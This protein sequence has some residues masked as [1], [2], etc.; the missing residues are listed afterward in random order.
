[1]SKYSMIIVGKAYSTA[2]SF[3]MIN[4]SNEIF[5]MI[6]Q[7]KSHLLPLLMTLFLIDS[8]FALDV[9]LQ[10]VATGL[11]TPVDLVAAPD[12][13]GRLYIVEQTGTIRI[14]M[15]DGTIQSEPFIDVTSKMVKMHAIYDER[16]LLGLAFHPNYSTNGKF[17]IYYSAPIRKDASFPFHLFGNHTSNV[18]EFTVSKGNANQADLGSEKIII[19]VDQPQ[20]NHNGGALRFGPDGYLYIGTGDGGF[21]D[22]WGFGHNKADGNGQD[23]NTLLAKILRIDVNKGNPYDIPAGNPFM[24]QDGARPEIFA[25]GFRNPWKMNFDMGGNNELFVAD[26]GQNSFEAV[27]IVKKGG[28]YGWRVREGAHC[29]DL[30]NPNVQ[31]PNCPSDQMIDPILEYKH[32]TTHPG[33]C[34]GISISGGV[35][36]RGQNSAWTGKYFFADYSMAMGTING[37]LYVASENGGNWSMEDINITNMSDQMSFLAV[38]QDAKGEVY[39]LTTKAFSPGGGKDIIYKLI[40]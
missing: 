31:K 10:A 5:P 30:F 14:L 12:G 6:K 26:V 17:Y 34:K 3:S 28:N 11:N 22:D 33:D 29:F 36:Y 37:R 24:D 18:S 9:K 8:A 4:P 23:L 40:R 2:S 15:P 27:N 7:L 21:A 13:S 38:S 1:M 16:G 32:C 19:Q 35:I 25:Y 20:F 39:A